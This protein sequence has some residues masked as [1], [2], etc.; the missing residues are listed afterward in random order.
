ML[1]TAILEFDRFYQISHV[2]KLVPG[3]SSGVFCVSYAESSLTCKLELN[4]A[5]LD[6]DRFEV[7]LKSA[8][9]QVV[10]ETSNGAFGVSYA[11]RSVSCKF[12][13]N[14]AI[15]DCDRFEVTKHPIF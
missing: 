11:E 3:T 8:F 2:S 7:H 15:I 12:E 6:F 9:S 1:N 4:H 14:K 13:L 5:I 10:V